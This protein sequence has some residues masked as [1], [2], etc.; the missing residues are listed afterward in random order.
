MAGVYKGLTVK[1]GADATG[2]EKALSSIDSKGKAL[3]KNLRQIEKALKVNPSSTELLK[4]KF[5]TLGQQVKNT[6]GRLNAL[7]DTAAK[8]DM[9]KVDPG[10]WDALQREIAATEGSLKTYTAQLKEANAQYAAA[11]SGLGRVGSKITEIGDNLAPIGEKMT[12]VGTKMTAV[13]TTA[14]TAAGIASVKTAMGF[15]TSLAKVST[16]A[17]ES[18]MSMEEIGEGSRELAVEYG[19]SASGI[20]EALYQAMSASVDTADALG[21]VETATRLSKAG[22]TESATAVDVLTTAINAYGLEAEQAEHVSDVLV[23]T[24]NLGKTTVAELAG[25]M[26]NVIPTA[27]AYNVSLENLASAYAVMTKQGI[28]TANSTTA[29]NGMLTELAEDGSTVNGVLQEMSGKT[30]GQLMADGA[31]LGD[32][33]SMLSDSVNGD[34]EAF[35]NLWGNVRASKGALAIA[36]AGADEFNDTLNSMVKASG[37]VDTALEKLGG[38]TQ[39]ALNKAKAAVE[40]AAISVGQV[41]LPYVT[42]AAGFVKDAA[43][44]FN[45]LSDEEKASVVQTAA[46][47]A[48]IGPV[49]VVMGKLMTSVSSIGKGISAFATACA[50]LDI[51]TGSAKTGMQKL[52]V[53]TGKMEATAGKA[54][55]AM[56]ALK[57]AAIGL[58]AAGIAIVVKSLLDYK[59]HLDDVDKATNGLHASMDKLGSGSA[60]EVFES[61]AASAKSAWQEVDSVV[62]AHARLAESIGDLYGET[63]SSAALSDHYAQAIK[64]AKEAFDGSPEAVARLQAAIDGYNQVTGSSIE[65][66][67]TE[68]GELSISTAALDANTEAWKANARAQAAQ[69]AYG[70]IFKENLEAHRAEEDALA[71][72]TAK[73]EELNE[74]VRNNDTDSIRTLSTELALLE[75]KYEEVQRVTEASDEEMARAEQQMYDYSEA[76]LIA[77][78]TT[79]D[80]RNALSWTEEGLSEFDTLADGLGVNVDDLASSLSAAQISTDKL[81]ALGSENFEKLYRN[82][83]R[84]IDQ[85][86]SALRILDQQGIDPKNVIVDD[87]G[88]IRTAEDGVARVD[89]VH[90]GN[91]W[92]SVNAED[93]ASWKLQ[94]IID[95]LSSIG[96]RMFSIGASASGA[97]SSAGVIRRNAAGAI[98]GIVTR[99]KLTSI[100]WVG[101]DGAEAVFHMGNAGGAVV[102]L[103]NR[104]YVRPFAQAV[105]A[106]MGGA[107]RPSVSV[108]MNLNY[109]AS[110]DAQELA[111]GVVRELEN[112]LSLEG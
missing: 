40:D 13:F 59:K 11:E 61:E 100:G 34:S 18:V 88:T 96:S 72:V 8:V 15:E 74:A 65:I 41:L 106:E 73:Q 91:K 56:G 6:E 95:K 48:G 69:E 14:A 55:V 82:A 24:Q 66:T 103:T 107:P 33:I 28:N 2:M 42:Q 47:V 27:A 60:A 67:N 99:P 38:T 31:S 9:D 46:L 108:Q 76:A 20:N 5:E 12:S 98:N 54:N 57:G 80:F 112:Y 37:V 84:D 68:T 32:V 97:I 22:F 16:L 92:F 71:A 10:A 93:N 39:G 105:A 30:F 7:K 58:A 109:D 63:E 102:P 3:T 89:R 45:S 44:A 29:I 87:K 85:I 75:G 90:I 111:R 79:D 64:D 1:L 62:E 53:E 21:F 43:E 70:E 25:S 52:N 50:R 83:D 26:G 4:Q 77:G 104:R 110:D 23:N 81:A 51:A 78:Q 36:N 35:A 94:N 101:E 19:K 49:L 86:A 17:D